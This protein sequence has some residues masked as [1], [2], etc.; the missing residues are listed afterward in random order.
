[1]E[2]T[3]YSNESGKDIARTRYVWLD[4][5][6][7]LCIAGVVYGHCVADVLSSYIFLF[8]VPIFFIISG[9]LYRPKRYI[10]TLKSLFVPVLLFS[11][12][13]YP[14]H[15]Y[16]IWNQGRGWSFETMVMEFVMGLFC[17]DFKVGF[18]I[19]PPFWFV[20]TLLVMRLISDTLTKIKI[21]EWWMLP[22]CVAVLY[23]SEG[24]DVYY[25]YLF[26]P[27][28]ALLCF[29]FF[30]FGQK[31]K[32]CLKWII[33]LKWQ[34]AVGGLIIGLVFQYFFGSFNTIS[35]TTNIFPSFYII[36][37]V[38]S[39][40]IFGMCIIM[41]DWKGSLHWITV[42]S[43]GTLVILGL[44]ELLLVVMRRLSGGW[45]AQFPIMEVVIVMLVLYFLIVWIQN[46]VPC[47][48]GKF[49]SK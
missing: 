18:P 23:F 46:K 19:I 30:L 14:W 20:M 3:T 49:K 48:I 13:L 8:H 40:G 7:V 5:S 9:I 17:Y 39:F 12:L 21:D 26:L 42:L 28:R 27:Q 45:S 24:D 29:P 44:H 11:L 36:P 41:A 43:N 4:Y 35:C 37:V 1:M 10:D 6:K 22:L 25:D 16:G 31:L 33:Q 47:L 38:V 15:L 34:L 32:P 2:S